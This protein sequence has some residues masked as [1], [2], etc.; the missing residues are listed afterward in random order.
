MVNNLSRLIRLLGEIEERYYVAHVVQIAARCLI[1]LRGQQRR[2]AVG[3]EMKVIAL[4]LSDRRVFCVRCVLAVLARIIIRRWQ[5]WQVPF[6]PLHAPFHTD[7]SRVTL[8]ISYPSAFQFCRQR[9]FYSFIT[10]HFLL[11]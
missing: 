11:S 1:P 4:S 5:Q 6:L 7:T 10:V 3:K 2:R 9:L 8:V